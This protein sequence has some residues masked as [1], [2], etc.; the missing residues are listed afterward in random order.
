MSKKTPTNQPMEVTVNGEVYLKAEKAQEILMMTY[1]GL[2][3]QVIAGNVKKSFPQV[4]G[5]HIT[6]KK[7]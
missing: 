6:I 4:E 5:K 7:M 3:N 2:R 1:D